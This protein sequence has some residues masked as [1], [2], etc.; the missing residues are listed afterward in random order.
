MNNL[1][2]DKIPETSDIRVWCS[3]SDYYWT[4]QYYNVEQK[5]DIYN[6]A[7]ARYVPKTKKGFE[8]FKKNQPLRNPGR[9][10][11]MC[12]HLVLLL[13][14]LM[15]KGTVQD[16]N[17]VLTDYFKADYDKFKK[18]KRLDQDS[19]D[20]LM[21]EYMRDHRKVVQE[22][23]LNRATNFGYGSSIDKKKTGWDSKNLKWNDVSRR[24]NKNR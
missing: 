10:P 21:K 4:F 23:S 12:K 3:C 11:G 15:E 17:G 20:K 18:A 14:M 1:I 5:V 22:R 8:A 6:K 13:S 19:Y 9:H 2:E 7:P 24:W 16:S